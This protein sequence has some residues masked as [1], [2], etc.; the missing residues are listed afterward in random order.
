[1][2]SIIDD[3]GAKW[4]CTILFPFQCL[5]CV[6]DI[7]FLQWVPI[8]EV[9]W[10]SYHRLFSFK[11]TPM[12]LCVATQFDDHII[13]LKSY[14]NDKSTILFMSRKICCRNKWKAK[15]FM[16]LSIEQQVVSQSWFV[17]T[18]YSV[19]YI[20]NFCRLFR[21][22]YICNTFCCRWSRLG[23]GWSLCESPEIDGQYLCRDPRWPTFFNFF[24][25]IY[26]W[27]LSQ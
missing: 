5:Q 9:S 27:H 17:D 3:E 16:H 23:R 25:A 2:I 20:S 6:N 24:L 7:G 18:K 21:L 12:P 4:V 14:W 15:N 26:H 22:E 11:H 1:M 8:T 13:Y 19:K 10:R